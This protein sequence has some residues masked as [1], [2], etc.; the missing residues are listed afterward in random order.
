V[1]HHSEV[2]AFAS[3]RSRNAEIYLLDIA[4]RAGKLAVWMP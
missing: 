4:H 2:L 3:T 1:L